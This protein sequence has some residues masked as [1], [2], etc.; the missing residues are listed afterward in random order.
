MRAAMDAFTERLFTGHSQQLTVDEVIYQERGAAQDVLVFRNSRY[1]RVLALDGVVQ[2]TEG[3]EFIYHE[4]MVHVPLLAH[5]AVQSVLIIGGGDGGSLRHALMH[6][7]VKRAVMVEIEPTVVD[8]AKQ[9]FPNV[10]GDAFNDPRTHLIIGDGCAY[11]R[12]TTEKFDAIIVDSTD[13]IGP[14]TVLYSE[15]FYTACKS[16]LNPG[17]GLR[18]HGGMVIAE[19]NALQN[20]ARFLRGLFGRVQYGLASVPT[21]IPGSMIFALATD[22][23]ALVDVPEAVLVA[24]L[25]AAGVTCRYYTPAWHRGSTALPQYALDLLN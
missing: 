1:G 17:G 9:Y 6:P 15:E 16:C 10:C 12:E 7:G 5:G 4:T 13:P 22:N 24:R 8:L 21:Y 14:G 19:N 2:V 25:A 23:A 11:V 20:T 18:C 3:D